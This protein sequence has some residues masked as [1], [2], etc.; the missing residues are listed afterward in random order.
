MKKLKVFITGGSGMLGEMINLYISD[1]FDYVFQ[2]HTNHSVLNPKLSVKLN[3]SDYKSVKN[4]L[5]EFKPDVIIHTAAISRP[6][7]CESLDYDEVKKIN[8]ESSVYLSE[9]I[10]KYG[11]KI[12]YTST[13]L[14]YDGEGDGF[15][16]ENSLINPLSAYAKSKLESESAISSITNKFVILRQSLMFGFSKSNSVNNFQ[17]VYNKLS[18]SEQVNLFEDQ[19]RTPMSSIQSA[20]IILNMIDTEFDFGI[21]NHGGNE[22]L[23]RYDLGL[24]LC[25]IKNFDL[26]LVNKIS[27]NS[28]PGVNKVKNVSMDTSK[29]RKAGFLCESAEQSVSEC[30]LN[31][32]N[33]MKI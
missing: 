17:I 26:S 25:K 32:E 10:N 28:V 27:M 30:I 15:V 29:I 5:S 4:F 21:Y 13:D 31:Y 23:S 1:K 24:L 12:I 19:F 6:E 14:V 8:V 20:K 9:Y 18:E 7:I 33:S 16:S 2:Y 22:K 3:L 11:I